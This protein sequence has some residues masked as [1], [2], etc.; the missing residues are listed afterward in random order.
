MSVLIF[1]NGTVPA[2]APPGWL[3]PYLAQATLTIAA[4][5]GLRYLRALGRW[6]D[7]LVGDL[8]SLPPTGR[9]EMDALPALSRPTVRQYPAGKD[10]TDLELALLYAVQATQ[11]EPILVFAAL[12]GRLDQ[13]LANVLLLAHPALRGR[14][15]RLVEPFQQA[16]LVR[17][18]TTI[19]GRAGDRVSLIPLGGAAEIA[20]TTGLAWPLRAETLD[21]GPARGISNVMETDT[22]VVTLQSGL[23]LC[24]HTDGGWQR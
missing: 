10:E 23:L 11:D 6:P 2:D 14:V 18:Q 16:W 5:G 3:L 13:A 12:G 7:V 9:A 22:A 19:H 15:V 8:D 17:D 20:Y 1:A 24:V 21:F 4:D